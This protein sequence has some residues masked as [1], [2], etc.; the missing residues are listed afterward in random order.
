[1]ILITG[2]NNGG[3]S[4]YLRSLGVAQMLM[5]CGMFVP[6]QAYRAS[7]ASRLFTHY[8]RKEDVLMKSGNSMRSLPG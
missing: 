1:M 4:T 8:R 2:A 5:Q 3:K 7:L 6:A